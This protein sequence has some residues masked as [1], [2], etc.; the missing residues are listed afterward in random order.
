MALDG[1]PLLPTTL[2]GS[3]PQPDWLVDKALLTGTAP[4]RVR[5]REVWRIAEPLLEEAQD[6]AVRLAVAEMEGAGLDI[7]TDGE[8]RRESYFNQFANSLD[9]LDL[10]NPGEVPSRTGRMTKVPRVVA[11]IARRAPVLMRDVRFLKSI[12]DR[13]IKVTMPGPFTMT[14]LARDDHYGDPERLAMAYAEA[15][16]AELR[17]LKAAG[18][19]IVQLDEPYLQAHPEPAARFAVAAIDRA[20][21][22]IAPPRALHLCFGYAYVVK[23]PKPSGYSFLGALEGA[24][25]DQVSVEAAQPRLDPAALDALPTKTIIYGVLDLGE[26]AVET[27]ETVAERI[28][29]ALA[30]VPAGRLVIA[31]DCGMKYMPRA[32]A[33]AKL[34]AM[35]AGTAIVRREIGAA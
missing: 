32:L 22:G 11:P 9:G 20:L 1:L 24:S 26:A 6:D 3:Y 31:P 18:A 21:A 35:V 17:D 29:A 28:R 30:R 14:M 5:M 25:V 7:L 23:T 8:I 15:V 2:V 10:D 12:T 19:D 16:N 4:P 13:P 34:E 27:P 33:R